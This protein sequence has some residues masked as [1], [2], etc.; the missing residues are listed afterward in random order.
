MRLRLD[1]TWALVAR[2]PA[3]RDDQIRAIGGP[4]HVAQRQQF[5]AEKIEHAATGKQQHKREPDAISVSQA[6]WTKGLGVAPSNYKKLLRP[7][8][9][10]PE[11][12]R[13]YSQRWRRTK[14]YRLRPLV[15]RK[16][17]EVFAGR[18]PLAIL[19]RDTE[20]LVDPRSIPTNGLPESLGLPFSIP[21]VFPLTI[22]QVDSAIATVE[23]RR[24]QRGP[25]APLN[26]AKPKR[27][28][29][30]NGLAF[31]R[32]VRMWTVSLG[33]LPNFLSLQS[34][35]RLGPADGKSP[36][37]IT[38]PST[39]RRLLLRSSG[40]V[41]FDLRACFWSLFVSLGPALGF[42]VD[43]ANDYLADRERW[44]RDLAEVAGCHTA[45]IK[46][47]LLSWLTGAP[48][49]SSPLTSMFETLGRPG[50]ESLCRNI[51]ARALY[52]EAR[53]GV[54]A[55]IECAPQFT[56]RGHVFVSNGV[57][58]PLLRAAPRGELASHLFTGYEQ[59]AIR[60]LCS[61][62][63]DLRALIYDGFI[64]PPQDTTRLEEHARQET[65]RQL[66]FPLAV[67]LKAT[68]FGEAPVTADTTTSET[69]DTD[70]NAGHH[71][72]N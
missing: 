10:F 36:H 13:G 51:D 30:D 1:T 15:R 60:A 45:A 2:I 22:E 55:M 3:L 52:D 28:T 40:L 44:H 17:Q 34:H 5:L 19:C 25:D 72:S 63:T 4:K 31:L 56:D 8:F 49:S 68:P 6:E 16:A 50:A 27:L 26:P 37:I 12:N 21:S 38:L 18:Q 14:A 58:L 35:G 57:G 54:A 11:S 46:T 67:R 65:E 7:F 33:G 42:T 39:L 61:S 41:D 69:R 24:E 53:A 71:N 23:Q 9:E 62:V 32:I 70:T 66:G 64:A 48:L 20:E 47:T 29:L 59:L 43:C